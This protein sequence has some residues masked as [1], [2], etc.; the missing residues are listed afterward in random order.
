[1]G[2]QLDFMNMIQ[3]Y[4]SHEFEQCWQ[5]FKKKYPNSRFP[6]DYA[7]WEWKQTWE[8]A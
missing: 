4:D 2:T 7:E 1:M 8:E 6:K 3:D 5:A